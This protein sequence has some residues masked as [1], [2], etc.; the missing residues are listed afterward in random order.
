MVVGLE[1]RRACLAQARQVDVEPVPLC[2][3]DVRSDG[4][5]P[6]L[7]SV[8]RRLLRAL[9]DRRRRSCERERTRAGSGMCARCH[10]VVTTPKLPRR[11]GSVGSWA[12]DRRDFLRLAGGA[13]LAPALG[14]PPARARA[15]GRGVTGLKGSQEEARAAGQ[16]RLHRP[17]RLRV[18]RDGEGARLLRRARP[19]RDA[20]EAGLVAGDPRRAAQ[21]PDRRRA[22]PLQH[23]ALRRDRASAARPG[24]TAL[25]IAMVLNNNGQAITLNKDFASAG[26]GEPGEGRKASSRRRSRRWR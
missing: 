5:W 6:W 11:P 8:S 20:R 17:H 25:K 4:S 12:M 13:A 26:Y 19:R 9:S 22:L 2:P 14:G 10:A 21:R 7:T 18:A 16:A 1:R 23:A 15:H 3:G 24:N